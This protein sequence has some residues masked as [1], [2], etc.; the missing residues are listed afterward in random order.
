MYDDE[1]RVQDEMAADEDKKEAVEDARDDLMH[2]IEDYLLKQAKDIGLIIHHTAYDKGL[3]KWIRD[4]FHE[5][6]EREKV[7]LRE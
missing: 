7:I 4:R 5:L 3:Q 6:R 1:D 2:D